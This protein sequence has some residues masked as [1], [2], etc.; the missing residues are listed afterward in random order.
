MQG[1][2]KQRAMR[3]KIRG[4]NEVFLCVSATHRGHRRAH[5]PPLAPLIHFLA[6]LWGLHAAPSFPCLL[7]LDLLM[8]MHTVGTLLKIDFLFIQDLFNNFY[9]STVSYLPVA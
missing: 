2:G 3:E 4:K 5:L 6:M 8:H 1:R 9:M 7:A